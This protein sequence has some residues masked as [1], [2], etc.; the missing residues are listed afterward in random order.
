M[1][2]GQVQATQTS[3]VAEACKN[4]RVAYILVLA[5]AAFG[6]FQSCYHESITVRNLQFILPVMLIGAQ[7][8]LVLAVDVP[9]RDT[10]VRT[11]KP[12]FLKCDLPAGEAIKAIYHDAENQYV[13]YQDRTL[14]QRR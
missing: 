13:V 7:A 14:H 1:S 2:G 9:G 4:C 5:Y 12:H 8:S 6:M 10:P 11:D 3:L